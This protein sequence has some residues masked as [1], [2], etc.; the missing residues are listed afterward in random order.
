MSIRII[1][2]STIDIADSYKEYVSVVP[3][4][5]RF[6][7][8]EYIDGVT[9][10]KQEFYD[11]LIETDELPQTSQAVPA[12]FDPIFDEIRGTNDS[13]IVLTISS[14]LSGTYQSACIA[15][16]DDDNIT[17]IDTLN[18][19][20]GAGILVEYAIDC[21]MSGMNHDEVVDAIMAK[22]DDV[23]IIAL[24]D[25][26]EY[27]KM[28]GRISA[29]AA[30]AGGLL[31][32]KPVITV[33]DGAIDLIGK[34]RGSKQGNNFLKNKAAESGIDYELPILLGYSGNSDL[35]LKKYIE[36]SKELWEGKVAD[37]DI[38]QV[39][40]VIGT[41]VGPGAIVVSFFKSRL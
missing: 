3:L 16:E 29:T 13:A 7:E 2:D 4:H 8:T 24:L 41:H 35:L 1:T 26:L 40:S 20:T 9:I 39:C 27:L 33:K 12:D 5:V 28:G 18:V 25:T 32:I 14:A 34:A 36:D 22:R 11:K 15:S 37:L 19:A 30:L 21:V 23:C 31:N 38:S 17:V 10:T 6:G